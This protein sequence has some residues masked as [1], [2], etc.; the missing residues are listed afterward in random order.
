LGLPRTQFL[1]DNTR[2]I[3]AYNK[4]PDIFA[5]QIDALFDL[6][7]RKHDLKGAGP[8]LSTA[9]FRRP[10]GEQLPLLL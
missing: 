10:S 9:A 3:I 1:K 7:C 6:S 5:E 4:S 8:A 2:T